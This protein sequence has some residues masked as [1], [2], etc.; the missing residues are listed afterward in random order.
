MKRIFHV[1]TPTHENILCPYTNL[2]KK[3]QRSVS[4]VIDSKSSNIAF[5]DEG[6]LLETLEFFEIS[7]G[8]Y[9]TFKLFLFPYRSSSPLMNL[10]FHEGHWFE[11]LQFFEISHSNYQPLN[12]L[13]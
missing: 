5:P 7:Y 9:L 13:L 8:S 2:R 11:T 6:M 4:V 12:F 10:L 1:L 3:V